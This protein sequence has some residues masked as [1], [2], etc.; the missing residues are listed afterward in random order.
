MNST[1]IK[2]ME[3]V[4]RLSFIPDNQIDSIKT[5]IE[6]ILFRMG[7][8]AQKNTRSLQGIWKGF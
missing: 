2:R 6:F 3:I 5:F 4:N 7:N 8:T 1:A